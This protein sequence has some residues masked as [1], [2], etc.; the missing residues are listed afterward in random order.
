M[1]TPLLT[2]FAI[3]ASISCYAQCTPN[4]IYTAT[5]NYPKT[6]D[7]AWVD[8]SYSMVITSVVPLDTTVLVSGIPINV[9]IDSVVVKKLSGMPVGYTTQFNPANGNFKGGTKGCVL[10]SG[11]T[12]DESLVGIHP[13]EIYTKTYAHTKVFGT[14]VAQKPQLDTVRSYYLEIKSATP[15]GVLN[16]STST[17]LQVYPNP[18]EGLFTTRAFFNEAKK[19]TIKVYNILGGLIVDETVVIANNTLNYPVD[20]SGAKAGIY[21]LEINTGKEK[22]TQKVILK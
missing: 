13:L 6:L 8:S 1:K 2:L 10:I 7:V 12:S 18:T 22:F 9:T 15:T 19:A 20:L 5:G 17:R 11:T 21:F 3:V 4:P 14:S 16:Y